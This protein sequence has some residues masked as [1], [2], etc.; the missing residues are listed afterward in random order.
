[1]TTDLIN[2]ADV[3]KKIADDAMS[4]LDL[5]NITTNVK[6][7]GH[8]GTIAEALAARVVAEHGTEADRK[9]VVDK[10]KQRFFS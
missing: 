3:I 1:M 7:L 5:E 8:L 4:K 9:M 10:L 6:N 2:L